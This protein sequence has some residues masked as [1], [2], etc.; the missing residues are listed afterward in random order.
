M[1]LMNILAMSGATPPMMISIQDCTKH[2]AEGGKKDAS[3]IA[4]TFQEKVMEYN[5]LKIC[6]DVFYFDGASNIQKAGEVLMARFP[7]SFCFCGGKHFVF[8]FFPS[9]A[10]IKPIK[11]CCV[12]FALLGYDYDSPLFHLYSFLLSKHAG[13][14]M[15]LD[16]GQITGSMPNSWPSLL[17]QIR[18]TRLA[19]SKVL[20][21]KWLY[22]SMP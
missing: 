16:Q 21:P 3:Y 20:V 15:C 4:N 19:F 7:H 22:D 14:I 18:V 10:K 13:C 12:L 8:L 6:T 11:V 5:S 1:P 17:W 2:M 9:I